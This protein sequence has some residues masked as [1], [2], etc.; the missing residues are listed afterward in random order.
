MTT[1][2]KTVITARDLGRIMH[3]IRREIALMYGGNVPPA[4]DDPACTEADKA[5]SARGALRM[6]VNPDMSAEEEHDKWWEER[7]SQGWK[8]GAVRDNKLKLHPMMKPF[9]ELPLGEKLKDLA[10]VAMVREVR[11]LV[12]LSGLVP[13]EPVNKVS[14]AS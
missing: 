8:Y 4:W 3:A 11:E 6:L 12:D 9:A 13:D 1:E 14:T 10:R 2:P 7:A 5:S